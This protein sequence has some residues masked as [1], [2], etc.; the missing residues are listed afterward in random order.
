MIGPKNGIAACTAT[1]N[2][3]KLTIK[4][5]VM[6]NVLERIISSYRVFVI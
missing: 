2:A 6:K 5:N 4:K 1:G 3:N